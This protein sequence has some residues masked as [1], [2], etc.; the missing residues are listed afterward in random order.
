MDFNLTSSSETMND[1]NIPSRNLVPLLRLAVSSVWR[2]FL[3]G[4]I[5]KVP[6]FPH[7]E[8]IMKQK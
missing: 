3:A 1:T 5:A 8:K 7:R 6:V 2:E 4:R